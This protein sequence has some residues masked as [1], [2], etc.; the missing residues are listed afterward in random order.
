M[1][2]TCYAEERPLK[3]LYKLL[4]LNVND[5]SYFTISTVQRWL[6]T[7]EQRECT[8]CSGEGIS[9][10]TWPLRYTSLCSNASFTNSTDYHKSIIYGYGYFRLVN[11]QSLSPSTSWDH[12]RR[13]KKKVRKLVHRL[14]DQAVQKTNTGSSS[15]KRGTTYCSNAFKKLDNTVWYLQQHHDG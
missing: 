5:G 1:R 12:L 4:F 6:D 13:Q 7:Q 15:T 3:W 11:H 2:T 9:C 10:H 14:D 8:S